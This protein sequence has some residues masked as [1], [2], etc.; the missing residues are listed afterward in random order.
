MSIA[1][2]SSFKTWRKKWSML[3]RST[4]RTNKPHQWH[5][6]K[7]DSCSTTRPSWTNYSHIHPLYNIRS[8]PSYCSNLDLHILVYLIHSLPF[9]TIYF[10]PFFHSVF[11][12]FLLLEIIKLP[13][14]LK[15]SWWSNYCHEYIS[16]E[17]VVLYIELLNLDCFCIPCCYSIL[18]W[19]PRNEQKIKT[20]VV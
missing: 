19:F 20:F 3:S 4:K 6:S 14:I 1:V 7:R 9:L 17:M 11:A 16:W 2:I 18:C 5:Y 12:S 8:H 13:H 15:S 10:F